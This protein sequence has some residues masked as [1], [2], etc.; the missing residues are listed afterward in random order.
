MLT[1]ICYMLTQND[2]QSSRFSPLPA[3]FPTTSA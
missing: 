3:T 1:H 2:Y